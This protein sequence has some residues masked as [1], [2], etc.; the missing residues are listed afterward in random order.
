MATPYTND[1]DLLDRHTV[2][3]EVSGNWQ[4]QSKGIYSLPVVRRLKG[5]PYGAVV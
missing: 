3:V 5:R 1:H 2:S 4:A